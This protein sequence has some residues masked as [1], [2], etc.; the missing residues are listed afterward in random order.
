MQRLKFGT[1]PL[2]H[3]DVHG[4]MGFGSSIV[5]TWHMLAFGLGRIFNMWASPATGAQAKLAK[6][7]MGMTLFPMS[8]Q[9]LHHVNFENLFSLQW[10]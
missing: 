9:N 7:C 2:Q 1:P 10:E 8:Q 5:P 3:M 6:G 4:T